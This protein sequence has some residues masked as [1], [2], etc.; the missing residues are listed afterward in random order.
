MYK[1]QSN[2][3][4]SLLLGPFLILERN[5]VI[6]D[7]VED[8]LTD[9]ITTSCIVEAENSSKTDGIDYVC[10]SDSYYFITCFFRKFEEA[11]IART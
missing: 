10:N 5:Y 4:G 9:N 1:F 6:G 7:W 2:E 11:I 3:C 8:S